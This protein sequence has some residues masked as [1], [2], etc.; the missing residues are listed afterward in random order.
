MCQHYNALYMV[1]GVDRHDIVSRYGMNPILKAFPFCLAGFAFTAAQ[2]TERATPPSRAESTVR[3]VYR[4]VLNR[5]PSGLLDDAEMRIFSPYLSKSLR[6]KIELAQGCEK[7]WARQNRGQIMKAPF[8]WSEFGIFSGA[9]ERTSP[10][11]F[12]IESVH[13]TGDGAFQVVVSF[14][15]RPVDGS[16]S[17]RVKD[18][19]IQEEGQF[20]MDEVFFLKDGTED[21]STLTATLSEGC[22]G[23]RWVGLR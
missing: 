8:A 10:E 14:T 11:R 15:Y 18:R 22:E 17:W 19:L 1:E 6:R 4:E 16:G 2:T 12:H 9:N 21:G 3:S 20:V 7:D 5:A 13:K 23:A